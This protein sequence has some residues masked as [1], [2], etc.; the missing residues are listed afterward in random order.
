MHYACGL[1]FNARV[2]TV[3]TVAGLQN[4]GNLTVFSWQPPFV[5]PFCQAEYN[6]KMASVVILELQTVSNHILAH[7]TAL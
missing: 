2:N 3:S 4:Y 6:R 1:D 7:A 5:V